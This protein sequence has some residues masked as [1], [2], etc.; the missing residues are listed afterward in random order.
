MINK[1][2]VIHNPNNSKNK[3]NRKFRNNKQLHKNKRKCK[4]KEKQNN[5]ITLIIILPIAKKIKSK[6]DQ[7]MK[8]IK[9]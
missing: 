6:K 3:S 4:K 1:N 7:N 8:P 2:K 9:I 5:K